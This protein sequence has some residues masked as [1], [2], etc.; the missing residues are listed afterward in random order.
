MTTPAPDLIRDMLDRLKTAFTSGQPLQDD[1]WTSFESDLRTQWGG[2]RHYIHATST[3]AARRLEERNRA[4]ATDFMRHSI[5]AAD[6]SQ[7]W[8][9]STRQI[10]RIVTETPI[11]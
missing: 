11:E 9:L 7:R 6:L 3:L 4:I 10:Q 8:G 1:F 2:D 5:S